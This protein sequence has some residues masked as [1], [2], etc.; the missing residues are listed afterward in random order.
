MAPK[1]LPNTERNKTLKTVQNFDIYTVHV[2]KFLAHT[3]S[4]MNSV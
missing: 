1:K 3:Q 4:S 2:F